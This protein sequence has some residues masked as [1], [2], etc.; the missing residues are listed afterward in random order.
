MDDRELMV[1]VTDTTQDE[2]TEF[3]EGDSAVEGGAQVVESVNFLNYLDRVGGE[4]ASD[5][6]GEA[7]QLSVEDG[8]LMEDNN[9]ATFICEDLVVGWASRGGHGGLRPGHR[10][11]P[12]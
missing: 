8:A 12:H 2:C 3:V 1:C 7:G 4:R 10:L 9:F 6:P 5:G 11:C